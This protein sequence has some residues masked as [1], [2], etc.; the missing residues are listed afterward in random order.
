MPTTLTWAL[1][2]AQKLEV[3]GPPV[4]HPG[5]PDSWTSDLAGS[6]G[7]PN[8]TGPRC[9]PGGDSCLRARG[10]GA[11][12]GTRA[13]GVRSKHTLLQVQT[14]ARAEKQT[15]RGVPGIQHSH[16][17]VHLWAT[18]QVSNGLWA[19]LSLSNARAP[20]SRPP[21]LAN[22]P[23]PASTSPLTPPDHSPHLPAPGCFEGNLINHISSI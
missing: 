15:G 16:H 6:R 7:N 1:P 4:A 20:Q 5:V 8:P 18:G 13:V 3:P 14:S 9:G 21:P 10:R 11:V 2:T 12:S 17:P 22:A 19:Q 23:G